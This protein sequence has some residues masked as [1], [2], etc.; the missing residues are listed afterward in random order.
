MK[1]MKKIALYAIFSS[2]MPR[3]EKHFTLGERDKMI[4]L[5]MF[6]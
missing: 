4:I 6:P 3:D 2:W 5:T 1:L